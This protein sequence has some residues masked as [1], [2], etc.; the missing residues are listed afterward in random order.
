MK[1]EL[2]IYLPPD[3]Q[4]KQEQMTHHFGDGLY[5]KQIFI[6]AG[7]TLIQHQHKFEHLSILAS[8]TVFVTIHGVTKEYTGPTCLN[9]KA[10]TYHGVVAKTDSIW[11]CIHATSSTDAQTIDFELI[12]PVD[13]FSLELARAAADKSS[14]GTIDQQIFAQAVAKIWNRN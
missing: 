5:A 3:P 1:L 6:C 11:Y 7:Q 9:I 12:S 2:P 14:G 4:P 10:N 13:Q 8:G